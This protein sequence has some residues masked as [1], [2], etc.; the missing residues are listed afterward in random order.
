MLENFKKV[1]A[2]EDIGKNLIKGLY[3]GLKAA[4]GLIIEP[5][6]DLFWG[7]VDEVK[8]LFGI[9][10]PSTVFA[11]IGK[12]L[13]Q[14]LYNGIKLIISNPLKL[15][16]DL[17]SNIQTVFKDTGGWFKDKFASAWTNIKAAFSLD[18]VKTFF[19]GIW[20][21]IKNSFGS[22]SDWF[23]NTFTDAWT[24]VKSVFSTGGKIYDGIKDGIGDAFKAVVNKLIDGINAIITVPFNKINSMLNTIR[25]VSILGAKP[26]SGLWDQ[27]PLSVPRIPKLATG[28]V[29]PPNSEFLALLGDQ[30]RGVNIEA[31][32]DTIVEAFL[33]AGGGSNNSNGDMLHVTLML[34]DGK[35]LLDTIVKA[36][37]ENYKATGKAAFAH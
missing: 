26:F 17:W 4:L 30:K 13:I 8:K 10:S 15:F 36:E 14:G 21:G 19:T 5:I 7:I 29:I 25:N 12:F 20:T 33:K 24:K 18:N 34:P 31:P 9:H 32:L 28:A 1:L 6:N 37:K 22:V 23:K 16:K 11:E 35:V 3:N 27:N 2:G